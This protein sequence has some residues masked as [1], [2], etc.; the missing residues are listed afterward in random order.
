[1]MNTTIDALKKFCKDK[2]RK[3]PAPTF[4]AYI[5]AKDE[6]IELMR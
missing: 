1:M 2:D 4:S 5:T 3:V 6:M